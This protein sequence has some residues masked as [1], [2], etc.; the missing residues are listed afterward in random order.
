MRGHDLLNDPLWSA[1]HSLIPLSIRSN[2]PIHRRQN[3]GQTL[4]GQERK[5][6]IR[7]S[8]GYA[9]PVPEKWSPVHRRRHFSTSDGTPE[10][11]MPDMWPESEFPQ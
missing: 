11:T 3:D 6:R 1:F 5:E 2:D 9:A 4:P 8:S 7:S 10:R